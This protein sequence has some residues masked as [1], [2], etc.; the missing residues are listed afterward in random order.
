MRRRYPGFCTNRKG[1]GVLSVTPSQPAGILAFS[2]NPKRHRNPNVTAR[3]HGKANDCA[4]CDVV[5]VLTRILG[6]SLS[7][8]EL[9]DMLGVE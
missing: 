2:P 8:A 3:K 5:T 1:T 9:G 7:A 4:V 6:P